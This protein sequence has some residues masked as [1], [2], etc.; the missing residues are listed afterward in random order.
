MK[1]QSSSQ[2]NDLPKLSAPT[3]RALAS[4]GIQ[5]LDQLTKYKESDI[6]KLHGLGPSTIKALHVALK[7]KGLSFAAEKGK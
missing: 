4:I 1:K 6:K 7:A 2:E 5:R 3:Q